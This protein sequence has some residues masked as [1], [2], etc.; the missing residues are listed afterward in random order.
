M[1]PDEPAGYRAK[2]AYA[3]YE[4]GTDYERQRF[5]GP[6]GRYRRRR[7][8]AAVN[9]SL[10]ALPDGVRMLD[11]PCGTGRWWPVLERKA[12]E[13]VAVDIS[14][15][16]RAHATERAARS[17]A[18]V[19][20]QAGDAESLPLPD[21]SVDWVFSFALTK[22]LPPP[23]QTQVLSEYARVARQGVISTFGIVSG[24]SGALWRLRRLEDS[25]PV[26]PEALRDMASDS[27]LEIESVR[28]CT[29]PIGTERLVLMR[30][31]S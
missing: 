24:L 29:T 10:D 26:T 6:L 25:F 7:E 23:I 8:L 20:V 30:Q 14:E 31:R 1:T 21:D 28:R 9:E 27:G 5:S 22:H 13:I 4:A 16:M 19:E 15:G 2:S 3:G 18:H 17:H 11:C 12:S